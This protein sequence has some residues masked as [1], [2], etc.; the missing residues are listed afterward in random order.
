MGVVLSSQ[1][2]KHADH[3]QAGW[4]EA[5]PLY[6]VQTRPASQ[7]GVVA[8]AETLDTQRPTSRIC[9]KVYLSTSQPSG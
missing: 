8:V 9:F 3:F 7:A 1:H 2:W 6:L 5:A 4:P